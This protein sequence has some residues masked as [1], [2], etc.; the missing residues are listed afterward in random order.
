MRARTVYCAY[1]VLPENKLNDLTMFNRAALEQL[2]GNG[3]ATHCAY[4]KEKL[5]YPR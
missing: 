5:E 4:S 3:N 2:L 1:F